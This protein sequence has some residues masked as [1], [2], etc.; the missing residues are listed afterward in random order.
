M[1]I[2]IAGNYKT[3]KTVSACTFPKPAI[4][5]DW[6]NGFLSV[7][8]TRDK[9]GKLVVPDHAD[10][11][12]VPF[13]KEEIYPIDFAYSKKK[14]GMPA[15]AYTKGAM[16]LLK[17]YNEVVIALGKDLCYD[18]KG[19]Y[20]T[21]IV[22]SLTSMFSVW[23]DMIFR[24]SG[25]SAL[26]M[27]EYGELKSLLFKQFIPSM[28]TLSAKM[29]HVI[30]ITHEQTQQD[31]TTKKVECVPLGPSFNQGILMGKEFDEIYR[32]VV[33]PTGER[34]WKTSK[35]GLFQAGSRLDLPNIKPATF[36]RLQEVIKK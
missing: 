16:D 14:E 27:Q 35:D 5:L 18:G 22:D 23:V 29:E 26:G 19:P 15:P 24:K 2:L 33:T 10:I 32:Q 4:M 11:T 12:V 28:K 20:K 25:I 7:Q 17:K 9:G 36:Q 31:D 13:Y 1:L 34:E 30:L 21:L 8:N 3:G 6:D